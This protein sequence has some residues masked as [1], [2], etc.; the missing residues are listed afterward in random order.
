MTRRRACWLMW[1]VFTWICIILLFCFVISCLNSYGKHSTHTVIQVRFYFYFLRFFF[2]GDTP[3]AYHF[4]LSLFVN[5]IRIAARLWR[6][7]QHWQNWLSIFK[8]FFMSKLFCRWIPPAWMAQKCWLT[9]LRHCRYTNAVRWP[10]LR[11]WTLWNPVRLTPFRVRFPGI[12]MLFCI[13]VSKAC[14]ILHFSNAN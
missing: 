8:F 6:K 4:P 2:S 10:A 12:V 1:T 13:F 9:Q 3:N 7:Y 11:Q 5:W 14:A